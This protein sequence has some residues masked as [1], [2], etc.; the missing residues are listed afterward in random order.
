MGLVD[1]L[2]EL[3][4]AIWKQYEK[5]TQYCNK[6]YGWN[7]Y[8]LATRA[9]L[10]ASISYFGASVYTL[11]YGFQTSNMISTTVGVMG[12]LVGIRYDYSR[13]KDYEIEE[14]IEIR[15][16]ESDGAIPSPQSKP[17]RPLE[18][19]LASFFFSFAGLRIFSDSQQSS[20]EHNA[21][22]TMISL[23]LGIYFVFDASESYFLDQI[24]APPKKKKSVL[25]TLYEKV[26]GKI[27]PT[28]APQLEP[29]KYQSID[30]I[31]EGT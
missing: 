17:Y 9:A 20:E 18:F 31:I 11:I 4:E 15:R 6:E 24:M 7:K 8:D 12:S 27:Q 3:D 26:T 13:K 2:T 10:G 5:V 1:K 28:P 21:L 14:A 30:D 16:F 23:A 25:K 19:G 22:G 29:T